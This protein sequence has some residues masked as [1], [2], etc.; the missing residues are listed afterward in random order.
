VRRGSLSSALIK[1]TQTFLS[2][3]DCVLARVPYSVC[4]QMFQ[5][6]AFCRSVVWAPAAS[7]A[8]L[9]LPDP[10]ARNDMESA[11]AVELMR[12]TPFLS[13]L[14]NDTQRL[15]SRRFMYARFNRGDPLCFWR[16]P[17]GATHLCDW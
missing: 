16:G 9:S 15:L 2:C 11:V 3:G 7:R 8:I 6:P 10:L 4:A 5:D 1:G 17:P 13:H 12:S 14:S